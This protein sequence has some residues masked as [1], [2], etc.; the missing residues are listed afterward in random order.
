MSCRPGSEKDTGLKIYHW[1]VSIHFA[2]ILFK[3][4]NYSSNVG[5]H[6][7]A[8]PLYFAAWASV[9]CLLMSVPEFI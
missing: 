5:L 4:W 3:G 7:A 1:A 2:R 8:A 9:V 6:Q